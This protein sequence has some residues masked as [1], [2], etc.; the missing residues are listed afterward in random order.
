MHDEP[1]FGRA[2][3]R[4]GILQA[5]ELPDKS[6]AHYLVKIMPI[7]YYL[8]W[9]ATQLIPNQLNHWVYIKMRYGLNYKY[10]L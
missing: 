3:Q 1:K 6:I 10:T 8:T 4:G 7:F 2:R 9:L 5:F